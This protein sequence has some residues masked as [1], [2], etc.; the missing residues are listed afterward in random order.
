MKNEK[1]IPK[2]REFIIAHD[3]CSVSVK[4]RS[5]LFQ[6]RKLVANNTLISQK[7]F[8][9]DQNLIIVFWIECWKSEKGYFV[10]LGCLYFYEFS[11]MP[12]LMK[13]QYVFRTPEYKKT[14]EK[15]L[16]CHCSFIYVPDN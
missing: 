8:D 5:F 4:L 12:L 14:D 2:P 7:I 15:K 10:L 9:D 1:S 16:T 6:G 3:A 13:V 11:H